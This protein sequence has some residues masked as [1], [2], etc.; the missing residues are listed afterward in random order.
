MRRQAEK[1]AGGGRH[2]LQPFTKV[3]VQ[4]PMAVRPGV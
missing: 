1:R 2:H 3:G 4:E